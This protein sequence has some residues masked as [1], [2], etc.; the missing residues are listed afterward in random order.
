MLEAA[1]SRAQPKIT[2]ILAAAAI[3]NEDAEDL[4][5]DVFA[6]LM[7][8]AD[9]VVDPEAWL[10]ASVK[11]ASQVYWRVRRRRFIDQL[12]QALT[13]VLEAPSNPSEDDLEL[14]CDLERHVSGLSIQCRRLIQLRYGLGFE[15]TELAEDMGYTTRGVRKVTRRC[16]DSLAVRLARGGY[17]STEL[18]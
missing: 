17:R 12:D 8:S 3:P 15:P 9:V 2:K 11:F 14:A 4:L 10:V 18:C 5:H 16:L 1:L 6:R 7:V 13:D